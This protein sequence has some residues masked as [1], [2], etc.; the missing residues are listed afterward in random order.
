M[1]EQATWVLCSYIEMY[2]NMTQSIQR[3]NTMLIERMLFTWAR[4]L[5]TKHTHKMNP[6]SL[7]KRSFNKYSNYKLNFNW[8]FFLLI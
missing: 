8:P 3:K 5:R 1:Y 2:Y 4:T 7:N 6:A